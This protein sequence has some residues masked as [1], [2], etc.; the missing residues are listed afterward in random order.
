MFRKGINIVLLAILAMTIVFISTDCRNLKV[1]NLKAN[2]HFSKAN[3]LYSDNQYRKAIEEYELALSFNPDL[4]E[5]YRF[6]GE[7]Y[8]SLYRPGVE[9]EDNLN[10]AEKALEALEKAYDIDPNNKNIIYSLGDMF[11][12]M[13]NFEEAEKYYMKIVEMEPTN[14]GN[15]YVIAD[16]YKKYAGE[17]EE[18]ASRAEEMYLRRIETDPENP[19]GYAYLAKFYEELTPIPEFDKASECHEKRIQLEPDNAQVWL[20]KGVNRWSKAYRLPTLPVPE[21]IKLAE[22]SEKALKKAS[23]LD[24]SYPE[25]YSWLSV[26]YKSVYAKLYP[27]RA[28][29]YEEEGDRYV[30]KF[31]ELRKRVIEREKL[32]KELKKIG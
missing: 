31:Q 7:C 6:L 19:Q 17:R 25:P 3:S 13:R 21:R 24:P 8:K 10:R 22:E 32:E 4:I 23:E 20:S 14:M 12:K 15:Y 29:R 16:F 18:L 5:A 11:D 2:Y 27:E 26:L 9:T 28:K 1:S 30:A